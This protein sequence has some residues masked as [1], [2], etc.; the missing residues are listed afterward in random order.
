MLKG[1]V[2][3]SLVLIPSTLFAASIE[4]NVETMKSIVGGDKIVMARVVEKFET[5][6]AASSAVQELG[7]REDQARSTLPAKSDLARINAISTAASVASAYA[8]SITAILEESG[9]LAPCINEW[10]KQKRAR[11]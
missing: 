7:R 9:K 10:V 3:I 5:L 8:K 11:P 6:V 1:I 4:C 2:S